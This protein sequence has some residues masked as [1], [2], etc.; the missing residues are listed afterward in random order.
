ME[1]RITKRQNEPRSLLWLRA[2]RRISS[3]AKRIRLV[4]VGTSLLFAAVGLYTGASSLPTPYREL[5]V[6]LSMCWTSFD[7]LILAGVESTTIAKAAQVQDQFDTYVLWL[8]ANPR[9][10]VL[11]P[12]DVVAAAKRS[13]RDD[14]LR[15]WYADAGLSS[16]NVDS[17]L[18]MRTNLTWDLAQRR[19]Y[20]YVL[21]VI[22]WLVIIGFIAWG[23]YS[24]Q[25]VGVMLMAATPALGFIVQLMVTSEGHIR[26]ARL[27]ESMEQRV[28][29]MFSRGA[30]ERDDL[31]ALQDELYEIRKSAPLL[32]DTVEAVFHAHGKWCTEQA[33]R[34]LQQQVESSSST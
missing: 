2:K 29:S 13:G 23:I 10:P 26:V 3:R 25:T 9:I 15:D 17:L 24:K 19:I 14:N 20:A 4:R 16:G 30:V 31:R 32:P 5:V 21:R 11:R 33:T 18:A 28:M 34:Q 12:E 6:F 7:Q 8:D 22:A 1:S 27:K